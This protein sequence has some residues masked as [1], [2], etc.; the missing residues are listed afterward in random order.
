MVCD[1]GSG[2]RCPRHGRRGE[3]PDL[4]RS[5]IGCLLPRGDDELRDRGDDEQ[6]E[7]DDER[8]GGSTSH[9]TKASRGIPWLRST[10]PNEPPA[11]P[12]SATSSLR[13]WA[14]SFCACAISIGRR[15][16][17]SS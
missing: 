1:A 9:G 8:D 14:T 12:A 15:G 6:D 3:L 17:T 2:R 5:W 7:Q 10:A 16:S 4:G 13:R 11:A